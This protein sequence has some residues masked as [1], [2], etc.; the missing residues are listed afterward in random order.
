MASGRVDD[1]T[2]SGRFTAKKRLAEIRVII[3]GA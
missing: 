2:T 3:N 1:L